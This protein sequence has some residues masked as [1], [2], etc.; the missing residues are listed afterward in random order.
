M[1]QVGYQTKNSDSLWGEGLPLDWSW[2]TLFLLTGFVRIGKSRELKALYYRIAE[3]QHPPEPLNW[4]LHN[5][6]IKTHSKNNY[7]KTIWVSTNFAF[8]GR[9]F[10]DLRKKATPQVICPEWISACPCTITSLRIVFHFFAHT[11]LYK[12]YCMFVSIN[13]SNSN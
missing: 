4:M 6:P 9:A 10:T 12:H 1:W 8:Y 11:C 5:T 7:N 13:S 3:V 2:K